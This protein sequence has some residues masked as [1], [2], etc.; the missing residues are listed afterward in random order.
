MRAD[1]TRMTFRPED[2]FSGV[3]LQQGRV[4]VDADWNEQADIVKHRDHTSASDL[5]GPSGG[6][7]HDAGFALTCDGG[8]ILAGCLADDIRIGLGRY[9]VD[10]ILCQNEG[11]VPLT[12]QPDLPHVVVP[13][14][15]GTY[16]AYLDVWERLL[17]AL[18][19]PRIR[20]VALGGPDTATRTRVVWQVRLI[21]AGPTDTCLDFESHD[22]TPWVPTGSE[23]DGMLAAR[24]APQEVPL[25]ECLVPAGA[26]Y[27]RIENQLYR[28]E[29]HDGGAL[30]TA[31]YT[32][33][34]DNGSVVARLTDIDDDVITI[35][36]SRDVQLRFA[37]AKFVELSDDGAALRGERGVV[38]PL[39]SVEGTKLTVQSWPVSP[40]PT[41]GDFGSGA[42]VRRWESNEVTTAAAFVELEDGVEVRFEAGPFRPGDYWLI[43]AR[44]LDGSVE[45]PA[46][47]AGN[48]VAEG[49]QGIAH[50]YAPVAL[51]ERSAGSVET[52]TWKLKSD[53]RRL[54][55]PV[56][57]LTTLLYVGGDGQEAMPNTADLT[58]VLPLDEPLQVGV[59]NGSHPV[60]GATVHF[61]VL[62]GNGTLGGVD[63]GGNVLTDSEGVAGCRWSIDSTSQS[64]QVEATLRD[65]EGNTVALPIRFTA[66]LSVA[67]EVAY[68]PGACRNLQGDRTV[69]AAIARIAEEAEIR[70]IGGDG[71]TGDPGE[72]LRALV[73][74]VSSLCG[75][76]EGARV[77]FQVVEGSGVLQGT[78][79]AVEVT[80]NADGLA[81][82]M[83][84]L[85]TATPSQQVQATLV[86]AGDRT[87]VEPAM[88]TFTAN[89]A[90][91]AAGGG[92]EKGVHIRDVILTSEGSSLPNEARVAGGQLREGISLLCDTPLDPSLFKRSP[93]GRPICFVTV[94]LPYPLDDAERALWDSDQLFGF[95]PIVVDGFIELV[96]KREIHWT[97]QGPAIEW[98]AVLMK[99]LQDRG[100]EEPVLTHLT[101]K[102]NFIWARDGDAL[103]YLDGEAFG[104]PDDDQTRIRFPSGDGRRGGDFEMWF[105]IVK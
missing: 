76:V 53:C 34:R 9:Y 55:P 93:D 19:Q 48:P 92:P 97:P 72:T 27:R 89:L 33:S 56:T 101:A 102:G 31:T 98:L 104:V 99:R 12:A 10:G 42:S 43:P 3:L 103:T 52:A 30:G 78:G 81:A 14:A 7:L 15:G 16:L 84:T 90:R 60:P 58:D 86:E 25:D 94:D 50:H 20:E 91:G 47:S 11:S 88:V 96:K 79:N 54:F 18:E 63:A 67:S 28:V 87:V 39:S 71:Q 35:A 46:D 8:D 70:Y 44:T 64:Q 105:W 62:S 57:E 77:V 29:I 4:Q 61:E 66:H 100:R 45:W 17:T 40:A 68:D 83:W 26:G 41:I 24:G 82:C 36:A 1:F 73:V 2:H 23:S 21:A 59:V 75:P 37:D 80:S 69:Q 6:P 95:R 32:W 38:V 13:T 5:I 65:A 74:G 49:P 85:D 51:L 22:G